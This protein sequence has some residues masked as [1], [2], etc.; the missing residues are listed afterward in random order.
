MGAGTDL[1]HAMTG[2]VRLAHPLNPVHN[3]AGGKVGGLD[4]LHEL[5]DADLRA[6]DIRRE[7][8]RHFSDVVGRD[9][10]R[11]AHADADRAVAQEV[12]ESRRQDA[13]FLAR[14][15]V[16]VDVVDRVP[17]ELGQ[18]LYRGIAHPRLGVAHRRRG[19]AVD[20]A[21]IPLPVNERIAQAEILRHVHERGVDDHLAVG[22]IV[23]G[24]VTGDLGALSETPARGQVQ[25]VHGHQ[26][27]PL[28]GLEP[29]PHV[30]NRPRQVDT[31]RVIDEGGLELLFHLYRS[32]AR[33]V[34]LFQHLPSQ[35]LFALDG[36]QTGRPLG[37]GPTRCRDS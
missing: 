36:P 33:V 28:R 1:Y 19:I 34:V 9:S 31:H 3:A 27:S 12:G 14:L 25:V 26:D 8:V 35:S 32:D 21:V 22:M 16:V 5:A 24:R 29:V 11:H 37:G 13:R 23:A 18:H 6:V 10:G 20:G 15:V 17:V 7:R 30:R 4:V 2:Q